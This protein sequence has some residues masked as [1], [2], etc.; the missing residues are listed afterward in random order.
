MCDL[1]SIKNPSILKVETLQHTVNQRAQMFEALSGTER[2]QHAQYQLLKET[3]DSVTQELSHKHA[4][5]S[6][7]PLLAH[8]GQRGISM[9][10]VQGPMAFVVV[11]PHL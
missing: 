5:V 7:L 4:Q 11:H 10:M 9:A 2:E 8:M 6:G 1:Y 3:L